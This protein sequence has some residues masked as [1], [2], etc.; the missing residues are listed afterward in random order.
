VRKE[1]NEQKE[2]DVQVFNKVTAG[3]STEATIDLGD[4]PSE[5]NEVQIETPAVISDVE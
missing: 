2:F 4:K 3:S 1:V 5:H